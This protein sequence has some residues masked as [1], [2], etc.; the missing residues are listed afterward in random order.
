[1]SE[2]YLRAWKL[3]VGDSSGPTAM[4]STEID[5]RFVVRRNLKSEPNRAEIVVWNLAEASRKALERARRLFVVL[6]VGYHDGV[7]QGLDTFA[8]FRGELR[9][10]ASTKN[11]PTWETR[12]QS[13]DGA[14]VPGARVSTT[15]PKKTGSAGV[16]QSMQ[17]ALGAA[18]GNIKAQVAKGESPLV[19]VSTVIQGAAT[20]AMNDMTRSAGLEWS[21]QSGA[22]QVLER[23]KVLPGESVKLSSDTGLVGSPA[24]D[25]KGIVTCKCLIMPGLDPGR[26]L[27]L[28]SLA[29]K[30]AYRIEEVEYEGQTDADPWYATIHARK[31]DT[32]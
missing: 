21:V 7:E 31:F 28:D 13:F 12:I 8:I 18:P 30:G 4:Q 5:M 1:M 17:K 3:T 10:A 29:L 23:G 11:G 19:A 6:E 9:A 2:R 20:D 15:V 25:G 24:V 26:S 27:V 16:L 32:A 14:G 22:L